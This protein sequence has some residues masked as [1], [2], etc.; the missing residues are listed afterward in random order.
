MAGIHIW[1]ARAHEGTK[2]ENK[3]GMQVA[4]VEKGYRHCGM[5]QAWSCRYLKTGLLRYRTA[6]REVVLRPGEM[7]VLG[8]G[9]EVELQSEGAGYSGGV[10][11]YK[12]V[13]PVGNSAPIIVKTDPHSSQLGCLM[14]F[15]GEK[16]GQDLSGVSK[17]QLLRLS[18]QIEAEIEP[19]IVNLQSELA[20][21]PHGSLKT[22]LSLFERIQMAKRL[23]RSD[24]TGK[25]NLNEISKAV[26]VSKFHFSRVFKSVYGITPIE[27]RNRSRLVEAKI[28]LNNGAKVREVSYELGYADP[29]SFSKAFRRRY[30]VAPINA[31]NA[32]SLSIEPADPSVR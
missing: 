10:S 21:F 2:F 3:P 6:M 32:S 8:P 31:A 23:L 29:P 30:G 5:T 14:K 22:R 28:R 4:F 17:T 18:S 1:R 19:L 13:S 9:F 16:Y 24:I 25:L 12:R 7:L 15:A 20:R 11:F 26:G 27:F